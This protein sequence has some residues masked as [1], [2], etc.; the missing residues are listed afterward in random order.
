[1]AYSAPCTGSVLATAPVATTT[2]SASKSEISVTS[3]L[4]FTGILYFLISRLYHLINCLS[5]SLK[6]GA[7]A[8]INTPPSLSLFS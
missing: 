5:F 8:A 2:S 4:K 3:V 7:A 6:E 1:M